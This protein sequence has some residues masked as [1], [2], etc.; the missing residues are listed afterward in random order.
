VTLHSVDVR[1]AIASVASSMKEKKWKNSDIRDI[2]LGGGFDVP[3]RTLDWWVSYLRTGEPLFAEDETRGRKWKIDKGKEEGVVGFIIVNNEH[4]TPVKQK[5]IIQF[6]EAA[7]DEKYA[8]SEVT[9]FAKRH[10]FS[11]RVFKTKAAGYKFDFD[12]LSDLYISWVLDRRKEGI[13]QP[14]RTR[15]CCFD[16]TF[17]GHR[18]TQTKGYVPKEG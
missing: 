15:Y 1:A 2:L 4:D 7:F 16:F 12:Y 14:G 3:N 17:T 6:I 13:S 18:T 5:T 11:S 9:Y 10:G 8:E